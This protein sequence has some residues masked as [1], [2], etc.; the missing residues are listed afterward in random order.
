M[1]AINV[2][3][4]SNLGQKSVWHVL[5]V[6]V[7]NHDVQGQIHSDQQPLFIKNID[8]VSENCKIILSIVHAQH[9]VQYLILSIISI[10]S[11]IYNTLH[12]ALII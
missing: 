1:G 5:L 4:S 9:K 3:G 11:I 10:I 7:G 6:G 12:S 8:T 2:V